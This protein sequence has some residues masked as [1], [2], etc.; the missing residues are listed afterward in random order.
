[1]DDDREPTAWECA[2]ADHEKSLTVGA[3]VRVRLSGECQFHQSHTSTYPVRSGGLMS[4]GFMSSFAPH[5]PDEEGRKGTV[6]HI[7]PSSSESDW[8]GHRWLI[9]F[10]TP[11]RSAV[12]GEQQGALNYAPGELIP[13]DA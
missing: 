13:L 1:M 8:Q 7:A 5:Q 12:N 3:R 4:Y 2:V 6:R 10:D 11:L 9:S